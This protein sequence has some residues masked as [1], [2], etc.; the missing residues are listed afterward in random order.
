MPSKKVRPGE[1]SQKKDGKKLIDVP[2][3]RPDMPSKFTLRR[4]KAEKK[5]VDKFIKEYNQGKYF[6]QINTHSKAYNSLPGLYADAVKRTH[7][8]D[9]MIEKLT[10]KYRSLEDLKT[11]LCRLFEL[12]GIKKG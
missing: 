3:K 4:T 7:D 9:L 12:A 11:T 6:G 1:I 8:Q 5:E 10:A 2:E